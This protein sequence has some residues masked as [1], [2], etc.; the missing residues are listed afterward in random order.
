MT[1]QVTLWQAYTKSKDLKIRET[2]IRNY[3]RLAKYVVDRLNIQESGSIGRDD[4]IGHAIIGLIDAIEHFD[5]DRGV[6][7]E[8][9]AIP[10][11]RGSVVDMLRKMDW[12]PRSLRKMETEI[13]A[14]YG[15]LEVKTGRQV[16]DEEMARELGIDLEK[17]EQT[18]TQIARNSLLSLDE[19]TADSADSEKTTR[20][21]EKIADKGA[22]P[23][24]LL[25][26]NEKIRVLTQTI[27]QLPE[28]ERLVISLYYYEGLTLKEIGKILSITEA[29]VSQIN[30]KAMLRLSASLENQRLL[31]LS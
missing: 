31:F 10:R 6:K 28:R 12:V 15:R 23:E 26:R 25:E 3:I 17:L 13:R 22:D 16:T 29:R 24:S 18:F 5:P 21:S 27:H 30:A 19:F 20:L 1:D 9:Y 2:L 14:A 8:T 7:F 4:L 11:I